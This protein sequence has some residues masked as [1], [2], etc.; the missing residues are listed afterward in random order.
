MVTPFFSILKLKS[1]LPAQICS[2]SNEQF[3]FLAM[4][5][6]TTITECSRAVSTTNR[7]AM[8]CLTVEA[9]ACLK[10]SDEVNL[11]SVLWQ[12]RDAF[13]WEKWKRKLGIKAAR[14]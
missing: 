11:S 10:S 3:H 2:I 12:C 6:L 5:F 7:E 13:Y 1:Y 4:Y 14:R 9:T 8:L